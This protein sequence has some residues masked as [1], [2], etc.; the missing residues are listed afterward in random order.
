MSSSCCITFKN[1]STKVYFS[2]QLLSG[3]VLF[4]VTEEVKIKGNI[5]EHNRSVI[6]E[7]NFVFFH[8]EYIL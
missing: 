4:T 7:N 6:E 5:Y 8:K 3:S 1:N 2:G